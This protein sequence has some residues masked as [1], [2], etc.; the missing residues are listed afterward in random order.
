MRSS[1]DCSPVPCPAAVGHRLAACGVLA[2]VLAVAQAAEPKFFSDDPAHARARDA[3]RVGR[4]A[5]GHRPLLRPVL[6]PVRDAGARARQRAR[7]ERQHD[8]RGAR[9]ELVHQPHRRP[10]AHARGARARPGRRRRRRRRRSGPSRAR[11]ARARRAGFTAQDANGQTWFVSFDAPANPEGATG[12]V[13]VATKIFWALG[14]NQVEYFLTEMR[15]DAIDDRPERDEAPPVR[16][17]HAADA[18]RRA[19]RSSNGPTG[20]P[21]GRTAPRP[22][23]CCR[24]RCSAASSTTGTRPDDPNDVVPHEH[25]R[26]L[27]AL[28]VFGAWTNLTDM[29]AGNTLDTVVTEG[30]TR[31]RPPLPAG[32]RLHV[33]RRR[34]RAA[35][36]E[37]G[38]GV[39]LR[40][41]AVAPPAVHL[42]VRLEPVADG[43]LRGLPGRRPLRGRR[44]RSRDLE[45]PRADGGLLRD[46]RRRRVLGRAP[47]HGVL[48]RAR[49]AASSRRDSS[50]TR[51]PS[52]TSPTSSSSG[53]TRSAAPTSRRSTRSSIPSLDATGKLTFGNAA[54][55]YGFADRAGRLRGDVVRLRQRDR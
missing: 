15:P 4:A 14:Y 20:V 55:Q 35:R 23:A 1:L 9:L 5:V 52:S 45:A 27:R 50:A 44:L 47:G 46:A 39:P 31:P 51:R 38:L 25:R 33:R 32:R 16:Q 54:V 40:R 49:S 7:A 48:G 37:R 41:R 24:A 13:V 43:R 10:R 36:L 30:G 34:Q 21:T 29:K 19:A 12:A 8:R 22:A 18:R 28:R 53:A 26:E 2:G 6:Q 3:G 11:R 17:A 42:R